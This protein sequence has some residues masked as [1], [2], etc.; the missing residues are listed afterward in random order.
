MGDRARIGC[1][2]LLFFAPRALQVCPS[3]SGAVTWGGRKPGRE[4]KVGERG[5]SRGGLLPF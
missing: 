3:A 4:R 2:L 1:V 5:R